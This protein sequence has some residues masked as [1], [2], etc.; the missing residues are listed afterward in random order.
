[1]AVETVALL[2]TVAA[3]LVMAGMSRRA[4]R[5]LPEGDL[6][7]HF[8]FRGHADAF[9]SRWVV[10]AIIPVS[11]VLIVLVMVGLGIAGTGE[12][13]PAAETVSGYLFLAILMIATHA[14]ILW[15]TLRWARG[16]SR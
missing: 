9:G 5:Q 11:H 1:M 4:S 2:I 13:A 8:D 3:L 16:R 6:P 12:P 10:L 15:L 14:F 7:T